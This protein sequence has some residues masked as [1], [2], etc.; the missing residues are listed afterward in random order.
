[1][2]ETLVHPQRWGYL[3]LIP[4]FPLIG[5]AINA[6]LGAHLQ[7]R[8]GK[9]VNHGI[10]IGAMVLSCI[11]AEVAFW[12]VLWGRPCGRAARS[13]PTSPSPSIRWAW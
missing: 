2:T 9:R 5:A 7:R 10:A 11:V 6:F 8:Y 12:G 1:V 13:G 3:F 4:L